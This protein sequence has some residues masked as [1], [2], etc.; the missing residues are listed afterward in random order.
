MTNTLEIITFSRDLVFF[1][2]GPVKKKHPV[3]SKELSFL[4][5]LDTFRI[6]GF[7]LLHFSSF[8]TLLMSI[9]RCNVEIQFSLPKVPSALTSGYL[10]LEAVTSSSPR[11]FP[12]TMGRRPAKICLPGWSRS[13]RRSKTMHFTTRP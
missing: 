4:L 1:R 11:S 6:Q 2:G 7:F 3:Y 8:Q 9:V 5:F 13:R 12:G 10:L